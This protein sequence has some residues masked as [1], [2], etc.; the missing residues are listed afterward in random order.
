MNQYGRVIHNQYKIEHKLAQ[1]STGP[2]YRAI[3]MHLNRA[4]AIRIVYSH[5]LDNELTLARF[6]REAIDA[7]EIQ[8]PSITAL[9]D[10]LRDGDDYCMVMELVEGQSFES[11]I[12]RYSSLPVNQAVQLILQVLEG[13]NYA[14]QQKILH[15]NL[16]PTN[17]MLTDDGRVKIMDFGFSHLV[18]LN[19]ETASLRTELVNTAQYMAPELLEGNPITPL[20]D[21]Y[22]ASL[23]LYKLL[24]GKTPFHVKP[25]SQIINQVMRVQPPFLANMPPLLNST[26]EQM[27]SKKPHKRFGE[28][29]QLIEVLRQIVPGQERV[30]LSNFRSAL[31]RVPKETTIKPLATSPTLVVSS[32]TCTYIVINKPEEVARKAWLIP[33]VASLL[34]VCG[35]WFV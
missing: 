9:Y 15:R 30:Q 20:S 10:V 18:N 19:P 22:A 26:L 11:L 27:L 14:H 34:L 21:L 2:V 35:I 17:L 16:K 28:A 12:R 8:H 33:V 23:V 13:L 31:R 4:V 5:L 7:R 29:Q 24:S 1:G 25:I 6:W 32:E 3:D